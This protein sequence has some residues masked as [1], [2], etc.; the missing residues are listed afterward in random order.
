[1]VPTMNTDLEPSK[2]A[3]GHNLRLAMEERD[4]SR[5]WFADKFGKS[6]QTVDRYLS[7]ET[8][9]SFSQVV[10]MAQLLAFPV[11]WF[12]QDRREQ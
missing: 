4:V 11:D 5:P 9:P 7:G 3:L 8:E 10:H 6:V 12:A 2:T 1:M